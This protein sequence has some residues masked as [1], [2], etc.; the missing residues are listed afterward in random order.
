MSDFNEIKSNEENKGES[1]RHKGNFSNFRNFISEIG[2]GDIRFRGKR[3]TWAN[4]RKGEGLYKR[5]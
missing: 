2:M 3:F 5:G 1:R 4:N